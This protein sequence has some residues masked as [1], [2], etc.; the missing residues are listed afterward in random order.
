MK[1]VLKIGG[2]VLAAVATT[3][4]GWFGKKFVDKKK[5]STTEIY[6]ETTETKTKTEKA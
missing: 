3:A 6:V 1:T 4:A 2:I 5:N